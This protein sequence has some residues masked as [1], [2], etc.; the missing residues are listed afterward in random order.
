[1]QQVGGAGEFGVDPNI[2]QVVALEPDLFLTIKGGDQW[3]ARL[4]DLGVPVVTLD[5]TNLDDLLRRHRGRGADHRR[6]RGGGGDRRGPG[7]AGRRGRA[8]LAGTPSR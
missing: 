5:A 4:R 2:E 7:G 8:A 3:K 1:M 6:R